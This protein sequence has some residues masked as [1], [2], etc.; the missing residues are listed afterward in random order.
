[1]NLEVFYFPSSK[2]PGTASDHD[3]FLV[4]RLN[5]I[6]TPI[7]HTQPIFA[8]LSQDDV[9]TYT[10]CAPNLERLTLQVQV[11]ST[12][13]PVLL[14]DLE[15]FNGILS[16]YADVYESSSTHPA[17]LKVGATSHLIDDESLR[18]HLVLVNEETGAV[19]G[20]FDQPFSVREDPK[21]GLKGHESDPVVIEVNRDGPLELFAMA[22]PEDQQDWITRSAK[23]IRCVYVQM[24]SQPCSCINSFYIE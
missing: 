22:V 14:E 15:S 19:V 17:P 7:D 6:E 1:M 5:S 16:Q 11:P 12:D 3:V 10:F 20:E 2:G 4:V 21:L 24:S 23:V 13:D 9:Y 18:G 8:D